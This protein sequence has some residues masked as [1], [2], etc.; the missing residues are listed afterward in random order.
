MYHGSWRLT[1]LVLRCLVKMGHVLD[2]VYFRYSFFHKNLSYRTYAEKAYDWRM[3]SQ[4]STWPAGE[5]GS[6]IYWTHPKPPLKDVL[7]LSSPEIPLHTT[8]WTDSMTVIRYTANELK[9]FHTY[10]AN[11]IAVREESNPS[12]WKYITTASPIPL[13][14]LYQKLQ[15]TRPSAMAFG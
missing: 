4:I 6:M 15:Q 9:R 14:T 10:V 11:R 1:S 7:S 3:K 5:R 8:F 13:M 2:M 12:H